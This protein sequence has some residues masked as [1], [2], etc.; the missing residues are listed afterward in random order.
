KDGMRLIKRTIGLP[1]DTVELRDDQLIINGSPVDYESI[2]QELLRD[3]GANERASSVYAT[4]ELPG[5][6]HMVAG[7]P[8]VR[9][10]RTFGPY[11]VPENCYF[12][13]GDNRDNSA[14]SRYFGAV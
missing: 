12:M 9:A 11:R 14:D 10:M 3:V 1:G 4:E 7:I 6:E 5:R 8:N 2:D 13:M